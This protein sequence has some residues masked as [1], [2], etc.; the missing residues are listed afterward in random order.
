MQWHGF[1]KYAVTADVNNN[2][3]NNN[4]GEATSNTVLHVKQISAN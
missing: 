2:N 1:W 4:D 3:N